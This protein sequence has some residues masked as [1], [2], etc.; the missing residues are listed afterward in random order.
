MHLN[1][2]CSFVRSWS[3]QSRSVKLVD[4]GPFWSM[5]VRAGPSLV[6]SGPSI[7]ENVDPKRRLIVQ[8]KTDWF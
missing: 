6:E 2:K 3:S 5:L 4:P 7:S 8:T 1:Q